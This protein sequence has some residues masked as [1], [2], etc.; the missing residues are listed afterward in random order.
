MS[1]SGPYLHF[2][3]AMSFQ[4]FFEP[5]NPCIRP[6]GEPYGSNYGN[7]PVEYSEPGE[8]LKS[9]LIGGGVGMGFDGRCSASGTSYA[10]PI[11]AG[12]LL[13]APEGIT[14]NGTVSNDPD[15]NPDPIAVGVIPPPPLS[16]Y[17]DG[18][19]EV[20]QGTYPIWTAEVSHGTPPYQY[21]WR[22]KYNYTDFTT[23]GWTDFGNRKTRRPR[24]TALV[25]MIYN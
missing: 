21:H 1:M 23:S 11:L 16:V 12:L 10:A 3:R 24:P 5:N 15:G 9:L 14:T 7:P 6:N 22:A 2:G 8:L 18:P 20:H 17:I 13:A 25:F 4:I 19:Q